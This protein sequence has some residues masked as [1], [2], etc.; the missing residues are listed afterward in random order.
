V[1]VRDPARRQLGGQRVVVELRV[2][3]RTR[4]RPHVGEQADVVGA[5]QRQECVE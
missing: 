4:E 1:P 5:Q 2:A 3:A